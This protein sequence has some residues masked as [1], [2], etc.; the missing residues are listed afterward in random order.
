MFAPP[1]RTGRRVRRQQA[2]RSVHPS[3]V[4]RVR[5]RFL[6]TALEWIPRGA[7]LTFRATIA[8]ERSDTP[9]CVAEVGWRRYED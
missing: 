4:T 9:A 6:L 7:Q 1:S 3:T 5:D 8:R 2:A